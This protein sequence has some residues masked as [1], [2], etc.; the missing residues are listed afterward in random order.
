MAERGQWNPVAILEWALVVWLARLFAWLPESAAYALGEGAGRLAF[1]LDRRHRTITMENLARAFP[2]EYSPT[3]IV[4]LACAVFENLGRTAVEA[5]RSDR[6]LR[7][8]SAETVRFDGLERLLE[9][10]RRGKGVLFITAHFGPWE[11]LPRIHAIHF[12]RIHVVARPLDNPRID[13]LLTTLREW[14]GNRVIRKRDAIRAILQVLRRGETVGILIDQHISEKEG[15]VVPFFGRPASTAFAPALIA[16][17]SGAAV[18]PVVILREG[19]GRYRVLLAD[20][21]PVRRSGDF[22]ADLVENTARFTAAIEVFIRMHPDQWFWVH[23]R[24]KTHL[25]I[26]P[27]FQGES[28]RRAVES[29]IGGNDRAVLR[30]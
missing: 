23:R 1:R 14:G 11:L 27:R 17:R 7:Q 20:E 30:G 24:W 26:D 9:A 18:L 15:V 8:R 29:A 5:A 2:E 13:D 28:N 4:R 3:E 19:P 25:P 6:L 10:Q 16:M 21:V 22:R 12:G